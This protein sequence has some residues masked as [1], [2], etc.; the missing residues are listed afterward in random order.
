MVDEASA[1][2]DNDVRTGT[3]AEAQTIIAD[4]TPIIT[5]AYLE[6]VYAYRPEMYDH[7]VSDT[8]HGLF[9]KR[10]FLPEQ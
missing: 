10:S 3:L 2:G 6:G 5:L 9:N 1:T 7:W 8:G 4:D